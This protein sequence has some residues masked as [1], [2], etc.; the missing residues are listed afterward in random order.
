MARRDLERQAKGKTAAAGFLVAIYTAAEVRIGEWMRKVI[1]RERDQRKIHAARDN[2][3]LELRTLDRQTPDAVRELIESAFET[4]SQEAERRI[5]NRRGRPLSG[6]DTKAVTILVDNLIE[7]LGNATT[8][9]GRRVEDIFRRE[10]LRAALQEVEFN[11]PEG[12]ASDAMVRRLEREG[13][14]G[15]VDKAGRRW[16]LSTYCRMATRTTAAEALAQGTAQKMLERGF[17]LVEVSSHGCSHHPDDPVHPCIAMEGE[18]LRLAPGV[19][20][21]PF[22]PQCSHWIVPSVEAFS[23]APL[24]VVA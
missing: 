1:G 16:R 4:G 23:P 18:T 3:L 6:M 22:H 13:I 24:E 14:T 2:V 15:F 10:G 20:L 8:T 9:V 7:S 19:E 12:I 5:G 17:D 21:P 11:Q